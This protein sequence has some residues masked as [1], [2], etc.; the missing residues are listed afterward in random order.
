MSKKKILILSMAYYPKHIGGAEVAIKEITERMSND[1]YEFHLICNRYDSTLPKEEVIGNVYVHRIGITK[2]SPT[3]GDLRKLPLH[4]NKLFFQWSAYWMAKKLH[5]REKFSLIWAMMAH[6]TGVP[7]ARFKEKFKNVPFVLTLQEGDPPEVIERTMRPFEPY[8][9]KA[10]TSA[11]A[12]QVISNFLGS[13]AKQKGS[14]HEPILIPNAV[15]T[16]H[17]S[18]SIPD[19]ELKSAR[20]ELG[21]SD[22][23]IAL[24][25]TSRLVKKNGLDTVIEALPLL[26]KEVVFVVF[27]VGPEEE[28]L[29]ALA[30]TLGVAKRVF[31]KG[32]ISHDVMPKYLKACNIFIRP[33][34][35]EGMGN[36][37][38]EAMAAELPVIA[39]PVGGI[40]DFLVDGETGWFAT[41]DNP[42]SIVSAYER[43][44]SN[45]EETSR[46]LKNAKTM[47]I[48]RYNWNLIAKRMEGEVFRPLLVEKSK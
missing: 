9:T 45:L 36:S 29:K 20:A 13:W 38:V 37:F 25:T 31:F 19:K 6:A 40:V 2:K 34:R 44:H 23:D 7:A 26:P 4:L 10:F 3:M 27:G 5:E 35:S 42:Q 33:S 46:I 17:F 30:E 21:L 41:V 11:D 1:E 39:T 28:S 32:Q 18:K 8:F 48:N 47:A 15:D 22:G 43:V 12:V 14:N 16:A 24:V